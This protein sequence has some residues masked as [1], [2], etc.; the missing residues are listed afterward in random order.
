MN[1]K[2]RLSKLEQRKQKA[3]IEA[4]C[5]CFPPDFP[6]DLRLPAEIEAARAVLCPVHGRRFSNVAPTVYRPIYLPTHLDPVWRR[7]RSAQYIKAM[8]ASFP[9]DRWPATRIVEPDGSVRF[10]LKDGTEIH[11]LPPPEPVYDYNSGRVVGVPAGCPPE[12]RTS[13]IVDNGRRDWER[14]S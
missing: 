6:P 7:F 5:I 14:P 8:D 12:F 9:P 3:I 2:T 13:S 11:R 1:L 10:V 4:E